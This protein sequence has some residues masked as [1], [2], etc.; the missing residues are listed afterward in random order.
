MRAP[1]ESTSAPTPLYLAF[2]VGANRWVVAYGTSPQAVRRAEIAGADGAAKAAQLRAQVPVWRAALGLPADGPMRSCYEAGRDGFWVH[3]LLTTLGV[4]NTVVDASSIELPRRARRMKTDALDATRLWRLVWRVG[5]GERDVWRPVRVPAAP[6]E[7]RRHAAR[8]VLMLTK[9]CTRLR[10]RLHASLALHGVRM[11]LRPTFGDKLPV[12][13]DWQ[14]TPLPEGLRA[15]LTIEWTLLCAAER[16]LRDARRPVR[17]RVRAAGPSTAAGPFQA[18][19]HA[20]RLCRLRGIA[21]LSGTIL[22][23]ELFVRGLRNRREVGA[24]SG[25]VPARRQSGETS[26]DLG[27]T[28][29]GPR[30]LRAIAV[31][32][33]WSWLQWQPDSALAQWYTARYAHAG[34]R[35]RKI[36]IV[37]LAR[38]LLIALW[39]YLET[40][41]PPA[42]AIVRAPA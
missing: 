18:D 21:P 1:V 2:E 31:E 33:A 39:R 20:A 6:D 5:Q 35:L 3:R 11:P 30:Y 42:G 12:L 37:A 34:P 17:Q 10:N 9:E 19:A 16:Q 15:R 8:S 25:L 26:H 14:G 41:T 7:D 22:A 24:L 28:R 13:T 29:C 38:K 32:V 27:V 36:G 23:Q 4:D 40:G